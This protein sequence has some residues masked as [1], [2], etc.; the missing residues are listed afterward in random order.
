MARSTEDLLRLLS[1]LESDQVERKE[2]VKGGAKEQVCRAICAFANDLPNYGTSGVI[3]IGATDDGRLAGLT[4]DDGLLRELA[5][6][7][8]QAG[9][10]PPPTM[11]VRALEAGGHTVAVIEVEPSLSPPVKYKGQVWIRV[12]PRRALASAD[13]ERRLAEKRRS[14]DRPFDSR[15]APGAVIDRDLDL[16]LFE[17]E[18]LPS[19]VDPEVL[20][21]NGRT[22]EQRLISLRLATPDRVPTHAGL[23]IVGVEPTGFIPGAYIQFLRVEGTDLSAPII[24]DRRLDGPLPTLLRE[25]DE[26]LRLNIRT[27]V[28]IGEGLRDSRQSDYPLAA[29]Q[30]LSRNAVLHRTYEGTAAPVRLTWYEDRVEIHSPGGP[31][32]MVTVENFGNPGVT[33]Y[34]N[35]VLAEAMASLGY[36]QR[37]GAGLPIAR[38]TLAANGNPPP[39]FT[40]ESSYVGVAVRSVR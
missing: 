39:E 15:P 12:G 11:T 3:F 16:E 32:G 23:L 36:V 9:I 40:P 25:L 33:D 26:L 37:F 5:D 38:Q 19:V 6:L 30:Q 21:A 10:L 35:P 7:R 14:G 22:L 2:A 8:D 1:D 18:Y 34:R 24:D 27:A 31:Y 13:E 28:K 4:V 29:L 20:A 17:R